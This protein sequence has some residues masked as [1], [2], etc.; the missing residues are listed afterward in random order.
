MVDAL[1][2]CDL[3]K[4]LIN[5]YRQLAANP[6]PKTAQKWLAPLNQHQSLADTRR[7]ERIAPVRHRRQLGACPQE[8]PLS[9][10]ICHWKNWQG[11]VIIVQLL[12]P[13]S[14]KDRTR[15]EQ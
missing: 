14:P 11:C 7:S 3:R 12:G 13:V 10:D 9:Q 8:L 2:V 4:T 6:D 5:L 1:L 15:F